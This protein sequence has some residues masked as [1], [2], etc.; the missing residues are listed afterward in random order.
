MGKHWWARWL[1]LAWLGDHPS[2]MI[3]CI[4]V[5]S[6]WAC[7]SLTATGVSIVRRLTQRWLDVHCAPPLITSLA[8]FISHHLTSPRLASPRLTSSH[9]ATP[10]CTP[11][12]DFKSRKDGDYSNGSYSNGSHDG[13]ES[14]SSPGNRARKVVGGGL[15][16]GGGGGGGV[17][18]S[19]RSVRDQQHSNNRISNTRFLSELTTQISACLPA[20]TS[21]SSPPPPPPLPHLHLHYPTSTST[22]TT[23]PHPTSTTPPSF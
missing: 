18:G 17:R 21:T 5:I 11:S 1:G 22:S 8:S 7:L 16:G 6:L 19:S 9:L 20:S 4:M 23:P 14:S 3:T 10:T 2:F 15:M 12:D 13:N